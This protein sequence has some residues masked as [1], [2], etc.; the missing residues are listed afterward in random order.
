MVPEPQGALRG[1]YRG[2]HPSD[3]VKNKIYALKKFE[4]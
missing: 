4:N 3:P 1:L 2:Y